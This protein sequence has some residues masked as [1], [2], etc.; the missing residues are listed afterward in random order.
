ML[1]EASIFVG[2]VVAKA[3]IDA[4]VKRIAAGLGALH[5]VRHDCG[6][7]TS[8][9]VEDGRTIEALTREPDIAA[10]NSSAVTLTIRGELL[11]DSDGTKILL[12]PRII[13]VHVSGKHEIYENPTL[14]VAGKEGASLSL[15]PR[16]S[17]VVTVRALLPK[18]SLNHY[19][20][21]LP[22]LEFG[23]PGKRKKIRFRASGVSF[24]GEPSAFWPK[25]GDIPVVLKHL[26]H[27]AS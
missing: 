17:T 16:S 23:L 14:E 11:N 12:A 25:E 8:V 3:V 9:G 10:P 20:Q 6:F 4:T 22:L 15:P 13:F 27:A 1:Y 7:L 24:Y 18:S 21:A 26:S 19:A 2:G 5:Y